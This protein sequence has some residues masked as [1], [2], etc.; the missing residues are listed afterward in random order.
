MD[1]V[2]YL[3]MTGAKQVAEQQSTTAHNLSNLNTTGFRAQMDSFR[4]VPVIG[5]SLSTRA[6]VLDATTGHDFSQGAVQETGRAMDVAVLGSGWLVLLREDG[7]EVYTRDGRLSLNEHGV[8]TGARGL[9]VAGDTGPISAPLDTRLSI[10]GDG[11]VSGIDGQG[12]ALALGRIRL[13]DFAAQD[14]VRGDDGFFRA[15]NGRA[16]E[17]VARVQLQSGVL[18]GSNVNAID[19]MVSLIRQARAFELDMSVL[20]NAENNDTKAAQILQMNA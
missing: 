12:K 14:L 5:P 18:E 2:I 1:R 17:P 9:A 10:A 15:R 20:K 11:S 7:S 13:A 19:A 4:S 8:L 6:Y 3:A 16:A